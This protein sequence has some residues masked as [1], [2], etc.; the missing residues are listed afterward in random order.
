MRTMVIFA[1]I[2]LAAC[3]RSSADEGYDIAD[4][5]ARD[6]LG[7]ISDLSSRVDDL[8]AD[9]DR[10]AL[11]VE[12]LDSELDLAKSEADEAKEAVYNHE[13]MGH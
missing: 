1:A 13:L 4:T 11:E 8:E 5:N 12:R 7:Q 3:G 10:L 2:A 6:A 9:R